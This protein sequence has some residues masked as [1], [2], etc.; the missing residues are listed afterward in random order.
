MHA[1]D[2]YRLSATSSDDVR[3]LA[4]SASSARFS[5]FCAGAHAIRFLRVSVGRTVGLPPPLPELELMIATI[6]LITISNQ[7][8]GTKSSTHYLCATDDDAH[9]CDNTVMRSGGG[10]RMEPKTL[11]EN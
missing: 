11:A 2:L 4:A 3:R 5:W 8:L 7:R 9:K 6:R 10:N 1:A